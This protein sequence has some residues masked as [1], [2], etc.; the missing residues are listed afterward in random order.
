MIPYYPSLS[1][2]A[3]VLDRVDGEPLPL[4]MVNTSIIIWENRITKGLGVGLGRVGD[5]DVRQRGA[6]PPLPL[7]NARLVRRSGLRTVYLKRITGM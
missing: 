2:S 3:V 1:S 6:F 5:G 4:A 7:N